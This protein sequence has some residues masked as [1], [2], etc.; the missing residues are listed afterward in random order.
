MHEE[1]SG[2]KRAYFYTPI[3]FD[4]GPSDLSLK[5]TSLTSTAPDDPDSSS[6]D[7][8][9]RYLGHN[10]RGCISKGHRGTTPRGQN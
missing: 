2:E 3:P 6:A 5:F 1:K 4:R 7:A 9:P 10:A 8:E